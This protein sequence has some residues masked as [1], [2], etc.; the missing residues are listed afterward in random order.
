M[1]GMYSIAGNKRC[2]LIIVGQLNQKIVTG[3]IKAPFLVYGFFRSY[4]PS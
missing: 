2:S 1:C 4:F 3:W